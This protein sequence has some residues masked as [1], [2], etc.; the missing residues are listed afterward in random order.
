MGNNFN[1]LLDPALKKIFFDEFE[2]GLD[3][4]PQLFNVESTDTYEEV[5]ASILDSG[6]LPEFTNSLEYE[7]MIK[8]YTKTYTPKE[9]AKGLQIKRSLIDDGKDRIVTAIV[10]NRANQVYNTRQNHAV[11]IFNDA[12]AGAIHTTPDGLSL[13]NAAHTSLGSVGN[14]SNTS[15]NVLSAANVEIARTAMMGFKT[16]AGQPANAMGNILLTGPANSSLATRICNSELYQ[17]TGNN[18]IN[19]LNSIRPLIWNRLSSST[20]WFLM[21]EMLMKKFNLWF[22]RVPAEFS[23]TENFDNLVHKFSSYLRHSY[24]PASWEFVYGSTGTGA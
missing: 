24:G 21:D 12:F 1:T 15:T 2:K 9:Y 14:Q 17:G 19:S 22:E 20:A 7:D 18:D 8:G 4:I 10:V 16:G 6:D 5:I 11:S 13:C 3:M 23:R